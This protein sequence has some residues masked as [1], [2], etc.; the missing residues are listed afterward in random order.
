MSKLRV[1]QRV[2]LRVGIISKHVV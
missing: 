2:K 1:K